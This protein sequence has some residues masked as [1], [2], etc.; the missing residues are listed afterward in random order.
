[1][2]RFQTEEQCREFLFIYKAKKNLGGR[3]YGS[4]ERRERAAAGGN[5]RFSSYVG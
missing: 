1:M 5:Q 3:N 4:Q 2:K